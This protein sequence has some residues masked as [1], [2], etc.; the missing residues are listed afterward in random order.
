MKRCS[1]AKGR[2]L[3]SD[4]TA[5][6][7]KPKLNKFDRV[8][9]KVCLK[10][11]GCIHPAS[12]NDHQLVVRRRLTDGA[13]VAMFDCSTEVSKNS[14]AEQTIE[15]RWWLGDDLGSFSC[16]CVP[17][18]RGFDHELLCLLIRSEVICPTA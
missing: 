9:K 12:V 2:P 6:Q 8:I 13:K 15:A 18:S 1:T 3:I 11:K 10:E 5:N 14:K 7:R 17:G 4:M 16:I